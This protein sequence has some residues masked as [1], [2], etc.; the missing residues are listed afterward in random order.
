MILWGGSYEPPEPPLVTGLY[1]TAHSVEIL[2]VYSSSKGDKYLIPALQHQPQSPVAADDHSPAVPSAAWWT[3][4]WRWHLPSL[5]DGLFPEEKRHRNSQS[6]PASPMANRAVM[7]LTTCHY[8]CQCLCFFFS[9]PVFLQLMLLLVPMGICWYCYS[10]LISMQDVLPCHLLARLLQRHP[11]ARGFTWHCL[12]AI[13]STKQSGMGTVLVSC[14]YLPCN[15]Y[16]SHENQSVWDDIKKCK[17]SPVIL[18]QSTSNIEI[19]QNLLF[20]C[21]MY[22]WWHFLRNLTGKIKLRIPY[23]INCNPTLANVILINLPHL[24]HY[25]NEWV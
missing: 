23:I 2:K 19:L 18:V 11:H 6:V 8:F 12:E 16:N 14:C 25:G 1:Q 3:S 22:A 24:T 20:A 4:P 13:D 17:S 15:N 10:K 5:P 9:R 7:N 21:N